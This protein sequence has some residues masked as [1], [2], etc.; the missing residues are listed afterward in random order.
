MKSLFYVLILL[1]SYLFCIIEDIDNTEQVI[2]MRLEDIGIRI[3]ACKETKGANAQGSSKLQVKIHIRAIDPVEKR[4]K[5]LKRL[6]DKEK[7]K[8]IFIPEINRLSNALQDIEFLQE[9]AQ[10]FKK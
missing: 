1:P 9:I 3:A 8:E 10:G 6:F 7:N 5:K 2:T 4:F